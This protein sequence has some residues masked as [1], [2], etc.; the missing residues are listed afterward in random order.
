[1]PIRIGN[2]TIPVIDDVERKYGIREKKTLLRIDI[3]CPINPATKEILDDT[4]IKAHVPTIRELL[5]KKASIVLISHQGRPGTE[6][7][8]S[9]EKHAKMLSKYL[10]VEVTF[11]DDIMGPYA[12]EKIR[13]LKPGEII[14]LDNIRLASEEVIEAIPEKHTRTILVQRLAPLFDIYINDAFATAHRSQ[15]SI[16]GFPLMMPSAAGRLFEKEVK[17]LAKIY[18]PTISPR[19]FILGGGKV[20][21]TIRIIEHLSSKRLAD[22]ILTTGLVAEL[23]LVAKNINVGDENKKFLE[24]KGLLGL[25]PRARRIL[26]RGAPIETPIDFITEHE[27]ST[28]VESVGSIKGTIR[29]IGPETVRMYNEFIRDA[30]LVVLRGPAGVI[31]DPRFRK[32]TRALVD[33]ALKSNAYLI[34]GGGHLNAIVSELGGSGREKMHISTAGGA[35]LLFLAGEE[36]PAIRALNMSYEKFLE[37]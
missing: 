12:R 25:V 5:D 6:D 33:A 21:D 4:R 14:L 23:F 7:F 24:S 31:E 29:D 11:I 36:L 27:N 30:N 17:A 10:G 32:G 22:R 19:I 26:L 2:Y 35:L 9:L 34:I 37:K 18:D 16:V 8:V 13:S 1:M 28:F 15:P 20:H 3:N